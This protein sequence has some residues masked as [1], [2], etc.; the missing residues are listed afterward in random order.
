MSDNFSDEI[1]LEEDYSEE[2]EDEQ[3]LA[4]SYFIKTIPIALLPI[5]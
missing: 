2:E 3:I 4:V 1:E 5:K